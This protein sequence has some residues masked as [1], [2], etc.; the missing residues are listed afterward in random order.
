MNS[1]LKVLVGSLI[2][3]SAGISCAQDVIFHEDFDV[4]Y[5]EGFLGGQNGWYGT[6][7]K[8]TP[9]VTQLDDGEWCLAGYKGDH[10]AR[11]NQ[12][13][14]L[15]PD[16]VLLLE[17]TISLPADSSFS[18][19]FGVGASTDYNMPACVGISQKGV[20]VRGATY[21]G[22]STFAVDAGGELV[23]FSGQKIVL[24]SKWNLK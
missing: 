11:R 4:G 1:F 15:S 13:L 9:V 20:V 14:H 18:V 10:M 8:P 12:D 2:C 24:Q 17:M 6:G 7:L 23:D 5:K 19:L 3:L 21:G 22:G 16:D